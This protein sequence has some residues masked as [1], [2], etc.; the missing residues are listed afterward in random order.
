MIPPLSLWPPEKPARPVPWPMQPV[1]CMCT[2]HRPCNKGQMTIYTW[3]DS[4]ARAPEA[5]LFS[6][7]TARQSGPKLVS[8]K[9]IHVKQWCAGKW[10]VRKGE[11]WRVPIKWQPQRTRWVFRVKTGLATTT[12]LYPTP[13]RWRQTNWTRDTILIEDRTRYPG[14]AFEDFS[15]AAHTCLF[16]QKVFR[17]HR[18]FTQMASGGNCPL[19]WWEISPDS[20]KLNRFVL[21]KQG[22]PLTLGKGEWISHIFFSKSELLGN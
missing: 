22:T 2:L 5:C 8:L 21:E 7:W 20:L 14:R 3:I 9:I 16:F 19:W 10:Q 11:L 6:G 15:F 12:S 1:I 18:H 17:T 4:A 13:N